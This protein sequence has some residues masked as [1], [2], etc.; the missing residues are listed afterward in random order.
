MQAFPHHY[1]VAAAATP[2]GDVVLSARGLPPL[3]TAPPVE[4]GGSGERWSPETLLVGA[5]A[6][7]FTLGFRAIA[8]ASKLEWR[9]LRC[10]VEGR[11]DRVEGRTLFTA[12]S[13]RAHLEVPGGVDPERARR[14]LE[15]AERSCLVTS[16]LTAEV[17]L[18]CQ[19]EVG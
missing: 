4:F 12:L 7:C 6:D 3:S 19:V 13:V 8:H 5:V 1:A 18:E 16:S 9:A 2:E 15:K 11:L 10:D 14:L 17:S